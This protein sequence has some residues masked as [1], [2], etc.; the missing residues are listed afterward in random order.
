MILPG[1]ITMGN[2][3]DK[4]PIK[5]PFAAVFEPQCSCTLVT[6]R[7]LRSIYSKWGAIMYRVALSCQ[8]DVCCCDDR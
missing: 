8:S 7:T 6:Q 5:L 4:I 3:L 2:L 1:R